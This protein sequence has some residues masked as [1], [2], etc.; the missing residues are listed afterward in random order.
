MRSTTTL[1]C[2]ALL[3][4][5][6]AA[7]G[8][9]LIDVQFSNGMSHAQSG[10]AVVGAGGDTWNNFTTGQAGS[11]SLMDVT[12]TASGVSLTFS[13]NNF[14][15][16]DSTYTRF[17]GA[18]DANLMQGYLVG[19]GG[20][21]DISLA[22]SG[23]TAGQEYGFWVYTQGDDNSRGRSIGLS[24]NGGAVAVSTQTNAGSFVLGDNYVYLTAFADQNGDIDLVGHDLAGEAN[25]NGVQ[26]M[27]VPEPSEPVLLMAGVVLLA[28]AAVRHRRGR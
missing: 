22:F 6:S 18:P 27:A 20:Q 14:W 15:E 12:N 19:Y 26:L 4:V 3:A 13:A 2:A 10:A 17:T 23:L 9:A 8:K 21:S 1:L 28:G 16:A 11:G 24:A 5:A 25:I 7:H